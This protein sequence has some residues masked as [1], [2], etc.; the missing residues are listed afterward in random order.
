MVWQM[1]GQR[2]V[3]QVVS[4]NETDPHALNVPTHM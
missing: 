2:S 3:K 4:P 1:I